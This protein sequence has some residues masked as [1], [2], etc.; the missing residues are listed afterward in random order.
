ML[1]AKSF[2]KF[3]VALLLTLVLGGANL[4]CVVV[5]VGP[6]GEITVDFALKSDGQLPTIDLLNAS[7]SS[8]TSGDTSTIQWSVS[9]ATEV[10]IDGGIG[11]VVPAGSVSASPASTTTYNLTATNSAGSVTQSVTIAVTTPSPPTSPPPTSPPPTS[12]PPTSPVITSFTASPSSISPGGNSTLTWS[13]SGA[14]SVFLD[15][16]VGVVSNAG[17]AMASPASTTTYTLT[18]TSSV[19]TVSQSVT[20][21]VAAAPPPSPPPASLPVITSFTASPSSISS[22]G[23][24]M[25][26]WNATGVTSVSISPGG[27]YL[28]ASGSATASPAATTTYTLT[29]TNA[30]GTATRQ[31]TVTVAAAPPPSPPP[32]SLPVITF[33]ASPSSIGPGGSSILSWSVTG[34]TSVSISPGGGSLPPSGSA[35][36]SPAATT[37]YTLT[38]TNAAGTATRQVTVTVAAAPPPSP[39]PPAAVAA[40]EQALFDAVNTLRTTNG[41]PALTRNAYIDGLCR[42]HAAHMASAGTLSHDN[43]LSTRFPAITTSIPGMHTCAE[44]VLQDNLPCNASAMANLWFTSPGHNANMLNAAYTISGMGIVIDGSGKIW[45]CQIFAGP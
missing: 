1:K 40:C 24:S 11:S 26:S 43:F 21:T 12:P 8:I 44:N 2:V 39:P 25:L 7:P 31:V 42:D 45:A 3:I 4:S 5:T 35:T 22:G 19:G 36:A 32:A 28:P 14:T 29:A 37:T 33:T 13:V 41:V 20:V 38:A 6:E 10:S 18:A 23:S 34:A 27:G 15:H 9:G 17:S 30:A 16:G